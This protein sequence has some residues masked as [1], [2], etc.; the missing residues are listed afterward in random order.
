MM[1]EDDHAT[2]RVTCPD[3]NKDM[4]VV[5]QD[6]VLNKTGSTIK[7]SCSNCINTALVLLYLNGEYR[8]FVKG[9]DNKLLSYEDKQVK[10]ND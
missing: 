1:E 4:G 6:H 3:C 9:K 8:E 7:Y 2:P 5:E 10:E